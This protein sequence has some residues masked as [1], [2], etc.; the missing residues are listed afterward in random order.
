MKTLSKKKLKDMSK[1]IVTEAPL[2][3]GT[4]RKH[5]RP[6][7]GRAVF[8]LAQIESLPESGRQSDVA[9]ALGIRLASVQQWCELKKNP[10]PF[11]MENGRRILY[12]ELVIQWLEATRRYR[13]RKKK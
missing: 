5:G 13:P 9:R 8:T 12:R 4:C 2:S 3:S 1:G 7:R 10:L 11:E 6:K